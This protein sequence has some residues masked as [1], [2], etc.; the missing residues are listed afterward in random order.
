M[1]KYW[2]SDRGGGWGREQKE[3]ARTGLSVDQGRKAV[4]ST[5]SCGLGFLGNLQADLCLQF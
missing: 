3:Q 2:D 1:S 5:R 4:H